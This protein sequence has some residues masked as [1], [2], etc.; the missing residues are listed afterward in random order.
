LGNYTTD[1]V[2]VIEKTL[3][4]DIVNIVDKIMIENDFTI[5]YGYSRFY[6]EDTNPHSDFDDSK[7]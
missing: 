5:A 7:E 4:K 6:F 3:T 2:L 1:T